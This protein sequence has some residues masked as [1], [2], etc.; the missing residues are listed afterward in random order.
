M[1]LFDPTYSRLDKLCG[2][3]RLL[4]WAAVGLAFVGPGLLMVA[5]LLGWT[6]QGGWWVL[7]I[8]PLVALPFALIWTL[9][10]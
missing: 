5:R 9:K 4:V 1:R 8:W 2:P 6:E 7:V 3:Q 10:P